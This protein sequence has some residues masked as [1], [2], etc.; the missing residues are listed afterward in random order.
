MPG[1]VLK[2]VYIA[3]KHHCTSPPLPPSAL[4]DASVTV[5]LSSAEIPFL[6]HS[7]PRSN[8]LWRAF[9]GLPQPTQQF[10]GTGCD[11]PVIPV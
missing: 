2:Q 4:G 5:A 6:P 8:K 9:Q 3:G 7:W 11:I 10:G 1:L